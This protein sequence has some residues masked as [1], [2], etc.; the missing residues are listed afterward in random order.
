[1]PSQVEGKL[2]LKEEYSVKLERWTFPKPVGSSSTIKLKLISG[3]Q[4]TWPNKNSLSLKDQMNLIISM[5]ISRSSL[6]RLNKKPSKVQ[7]NLLRLRQFKKPKSYEF[8]IIASLKSPS[9]I[10]KDRS[11]RKKNSRRILK[12]RK[13]GKFSKFQVMSSKNQKTILRS[14]TRESISYCNRYMS[15]SKR[16]MG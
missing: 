3:K 11:R 16:E 1:M 13:K 5:Q 14:L 4:M 7:S 6:D 10:A 2:Y 9:R 15:N 8:K 12:E